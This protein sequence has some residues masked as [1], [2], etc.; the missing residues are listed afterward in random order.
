VDNV[1]DKA[2]NAKEMPKSTF[3]VVPTT[4]ILAVGQFTKPPTPEQIKEIFPKEV[5]ATLRL[6][7]AGKIDQWW[8]RQTQ[9]GPVFLLNV[10]SLEEVSLR[11][12]DENQIR[13]GPPH[14]TLAQ[15]L[16]RGYSSDR[17]QHAAL[18]HPQT[19]G[20]CDARQPRGCRSLRRVH[21]EADGNLLG[22]R[23]GLHNAPRGDSHRVEI[24]SCRERCHR[25]WFVRVHRCRRPGRS[26][27]H[28][29]VPAGRGGDTDRHGPTVCI[30]QQIS[31]DTAVV[32]TRSARR[33]VD[34]ALRGCRCLGRG[35]GIT[36]AA[37]CCEILPAPNWGGYVGDQPHRFW[38]IADRI[39]HLMEKGI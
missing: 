17:E 11:T 8:I 37:C 28:L 25:T 2:A 22:L 10:T 15:I 3:P 39:F 7:L 19:D 13:W 32:C 4:R 24:L 31:G 29:C 20:I 33:E 9:T 14:H 5:P 16:L 6:Y 12:D 23:A 27:A 38:P 35:D 1:R 21:F 26:R 34:R 18:P 30:F 36:S